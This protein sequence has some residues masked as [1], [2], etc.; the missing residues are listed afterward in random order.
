MTI[1]REN[2][3]DTIEEWTDTTSESGYH[4]GNSIGFHDK[5]LEEAKSFTQ[6]D[7]K[8]LYEKFLE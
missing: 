7:L 5:I 8:Y 2:F 6:E 3:W 4:F 1:E